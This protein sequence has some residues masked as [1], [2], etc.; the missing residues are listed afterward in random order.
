VESPSPELPIGSLDEL[1]KK[2]SG[3][4][5]FLLALALLMTV[6]VTG[7]SLLVLPRRIRPRAQGMLTA[8]KSNQKNLATA[9]EMYASDFKGHYP[10]RFDL[11]EGTYLKTIPTCPSANFDT[12]S[13][14]YIVTTSPDRF[15]FYCKGN[16][17]KDALRDLDN[18]ENLPS[19]HSDR[20]L[21]W[22]QEVQK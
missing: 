8:C 5:Q 1:P 19:Y 3:G 17:H 9:L 10:A 11:L 4:C 2:K 16:Y 22:G 13:A 15:S 21:Y 6:I 7:V 18:S 12:Y 20:G 14:T